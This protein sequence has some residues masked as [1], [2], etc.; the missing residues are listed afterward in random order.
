MS[1]GYRKDILFAQAEDFDLNDVLVEPLAANETLKGKPK[2]FI[3][4]A[5]K[6]NY[7]MECDA[8]PYREIRANKNDI[9]IAYSTF[10]GHVSIRDPN[11]GT[12]FIQELCNAIE[13]DGH[14]PISEVMKAVRKKFMEK[15]YAQSPTDQTNLLKDFN[16]AR[17]LKKK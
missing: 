14:Y 13:T 1:H 10:E 7:R 3:I 17:L 15:K 11:S 6:G 4:Q 16:F 2:L 5:C 12:F 8:T 9:F